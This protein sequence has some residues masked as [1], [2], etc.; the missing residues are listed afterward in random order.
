M[1]EHLILIVPILIVVLL[2]G[3]A[4]AQGVK[5]AKAGAVL[6][7]DGV[8]VYIDG[9]DAWPD[10]QRGQTLRMSGILVVRKHIAD[11]VDQHGQIAQGAWGKQ[12]V[13]THPVP[14]P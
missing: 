10:G 1:R 2:A 7:I 13:L 4:G 11:P 6:L 5:D 12:Y 9:Q 3:F 8:P 14:A